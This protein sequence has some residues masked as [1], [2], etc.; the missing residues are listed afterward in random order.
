M[1]FAGVILPFQNQVFF[2][3]SSRPSFTLRHFWVAG[4]F[5]AVE[6]PLE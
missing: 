2:S 4:G 3:S 5:V 1:I 6:G